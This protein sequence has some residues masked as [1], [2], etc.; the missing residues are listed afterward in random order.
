M[1][2]GI[3]ERNGNWYV[4]FYAHG[5]RIRKKVGPDKKLAKSIVRKKM[6]EVAENRFLN[7][8][9]N[10]DVK[11]KDFGKQFIELHSKQHKK[12]WKS[13]F[14][15]LN[16]LSSVFGGRFLYEI[17]PKAIEEFK[18]K[19]SENVSPAT[20][21]RELATL[22]TMLSKAVQ[23]DILENSPAKNIKFLRENNR[24]V[25]YLEKAEI[26]RLLNC[27]FGYIKPIIIMALNT[28]M[29]KGEIL[30]LKWRDIDYKRGII[31]LLDTKNNDKREVPMSSFVK[32]ALVRVPKH[33]DS[34][35]IFCNKAGK[36]Y[37]DIRKSFFTSLKKA[38]IINF[39]FH[40]LRHTFASQLV[41]SGV[42]LNTVRELMGHRDIKMTL[43]YAHLSPDHKR[44]AVELLGN[45]M[46]TIWSLR[47]I[48]KTDKKEQALQHIVN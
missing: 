25:R 16:T 22:K 13:D 38:S 10:K 4:D 3:Y 46:D 6:V 28:G 39:R 23:W 9:K 5:K 43:R 47:P 41:M 26:K 11:F 20:V 48:S 8:S 24:R 36:P 45:Q 2:D 42:D 40:D 7:V 33:P 32:R 37:K 14:Y 44:R 35:Y 29:R 18:A 31:Y 27:S 19:R 15:N 1:P 30:G 34:P 17:A 21:N 12:S